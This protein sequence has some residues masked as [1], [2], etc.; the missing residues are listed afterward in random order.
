M[1]LFLASCEKNESYLDLEK[2][3]GSATIQGVVTYNQGERLDGNS[4]VMFQQPLANAE[5]VVSVNYSEYQDKSEGIKKY[6]TTTDANGKFSIDIPVGLKTINAKVGVKSFMAEYYSYDLVIGETKVNA[7]YEVSEEE[8]VSLT[9][10]DL[11]W[12]AIQMD[13]KK[14]NTSTDKSIK[15]SVAGKVSTYYEKQVRSEIDDEVEGVERETKAAENVQVIVKFNNNSTKEELMYLVT[16]NASGE[17]TVAANLFTRWDL[18]DVICEVE[19][20]PY[21]GDFKHYFEMLNYD[22][23]ERSW[24]SQSI[25]GLYK[26]SSTSKQ[27]STDNTIQTLKLQEIVI[28]FEPEDNCSIKGIGNEIDNASEDYK[29]YKSNPMGWASCK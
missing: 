12:V 14:D 20:K 13:A 26:S 28:N 2:I 5:V 8:E 16:T 1:G 3:N 10:N 6:T 4:V 25:K 18:K 19:T 23:S 21:T 9:S 15:V 27:V 17:Y 24:K 22:D 29:I 11:K 7:I